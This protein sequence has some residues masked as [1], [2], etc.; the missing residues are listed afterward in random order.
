MSYAIEAEGL[1][2]RFGSTTA[3]NGVDLAVPT[4][5]ILGV[6]GPNGAGKTTAVRVLATLIKPDA[7]RA[8]VGGF[9]VLTQAQS[10]RARIAVTG[11]YA[12][13][14]ED[15][16][17][18]ENL[19]MIGRLLELSRRDAKARARELLERFELTEAAGR[20]AKTY[21][22][23][24]RR[25]LD[26]A[27]SLVGHPDVIYLDEPTTGL[28]PRSRGEVWSTIRALVADGV[29]VLLTTQYLDEAD[30]LADSIA[31]IDRGELIATGTPDQLKAQVGDQTIEVH[32][33]DEADLADVEAIVAAVTRVRPTRNQAR[34]L[35]TAPVAEPTL[36]ADVV[37]RLDDA[38][39]AVGELGLR[40]ASL[41]EV[42][43]TLTGHPAEDA[44]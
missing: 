19:T 20:S 39:I 26:L 33:L 44:A 30:Q 36:L 27:A 8:R 28:D 3:L 14:D 34:G 16:T 9:D 12:S 21:S 23:G 18:T 13:I 10:V 31:V 41:D 25:R 11:Q 4:G 40:R 43:L 22:G 15:L 35:V 42:F 2:K 1:V 6:L 32:P 24:M 7:G 17:G 38:G 29:T 5:T 37:R